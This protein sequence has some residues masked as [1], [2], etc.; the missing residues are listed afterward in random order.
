[1]PAAGITVGIEY[2]CLWAPRQASRKALPRPGELISLSEVAKTRDVGLELQR[3]GAGRSVTLLADDDF[4][5]AMDL[6][7]LRLPFE[8]FFSPGTRFAIAQVVFFPEHE[9]DDVGV[10][11][12]RT[13]L[14]QIRQLRSLVLAVLDLTRQLRQ[15]HDRH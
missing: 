15:R 11:L 5:F 9:Q 14:A 8:V 6:G 1:M 12:D 2:R 10:L 4:G 7:H 13:R 3:H